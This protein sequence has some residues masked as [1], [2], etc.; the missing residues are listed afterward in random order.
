M[1]EHNYL[2]NNLSPIEHFIVPVDYFLEVGPQ[3][4]DQLLE[5]TPLLHIERHFL[6]I[7]LVLVV[8]SQRN[9]D[10]RTLLDD[11]LAQSVEV[12]PIFRGN[13]LWTVT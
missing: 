4:D 12:L 6:L 10:Q 5:C 7:F 3:H 9:E 1:P 11:G 8:F 13:I 2:K